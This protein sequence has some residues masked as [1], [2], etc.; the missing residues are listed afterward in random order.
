LGVRFNF[1]LLK[2]NSTEISPRGQIAHARRK[3]S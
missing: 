2:R 3:G 1:A